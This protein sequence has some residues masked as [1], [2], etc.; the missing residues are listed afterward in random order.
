RP[1]L[2]PL[3]FTLLIW[4]VLNAIADVL[5]RFRVPRWF[6]WFGAFALLVTGIY[7]LTLIVG[8]EAAQL[9]AD[10]PGYVAKL[11]DA[12]MKRLAPLHLGINVEDLFTRSDVAGMLAI[13]AGSLGTSAFGLIQILIYLGFLLAEQNDLTGKIVR[14]QSDPTRRGEGQAILRRI[15]A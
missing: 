11:Q 12:L 9:A 6:A 5:V 7:L 8:N 14:L 13:V 1:L 3:V 4:A 15:A 10:A 2:V